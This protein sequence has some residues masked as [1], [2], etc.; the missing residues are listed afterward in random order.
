M[1][2]SIV[3]LLLLVLTGCSSLMES[4]SYVN[5]QIDSSFY[6]KVGVL[7]F[8]NLAEDRVASEKVGDVFMTEVLMA[9]QLDV[10]EPGQLNQVVAQVTKSNVAATGQELSAAQLKEIAEFAGVQGLFIGTVEEY[11]MVQLGGEQY[12]MISLTAKFIDAPSGTVAWQHSLS[13]TGGPNLPI[14]SIG[15]SFTLG[16]LTQKACEQAVRDFYK[17]ALAK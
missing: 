11:K 15:E 13:A 8:R 7:P 14:I 16:Q 2:R 17:K 10:M 6:H 4:R 9:G 5:P 12:P 3:A 1:K